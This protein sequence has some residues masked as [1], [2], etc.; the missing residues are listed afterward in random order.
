MDEFE[1]LNPSHNANEFVKHSKKLIISDESWKMIFDSKAKQLDS[2]SYP[3]IIAAELTKIVHCV[4]NI[5]KKVIGKK[6][7]TI[8]A[9]CAHG[10]NETDSLNRNCLIVICHAEILTF[11]TIM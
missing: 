8:F 3:S 6:G 4:I 9:Y 11:F 2:H 1:R 10:R 7:I 5:H